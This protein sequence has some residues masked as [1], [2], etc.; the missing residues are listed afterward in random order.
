M[1][2]CISRFDGLKMLMKNKHFKDIILSWYLQDFKSH[3]REKTE[4]NKFNG[5][6]D[7]VSENE[8]IGMVAFERML[9]R[10]KKEATV[11]KTTLDSIGK[12]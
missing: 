1:Q 8:L 4:D 2:A 12:T 7:A 5:M 6:E 9:L 3:V 10:I 11:A